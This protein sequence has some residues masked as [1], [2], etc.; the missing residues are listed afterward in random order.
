[1]EGTG[2]E[3][4]AFVLSSCCSGGRSRT[5]REQVAAEG[6]P[7]WSAW[8]LGSRGAVHAARE[9]WLPDAVDKGSGVPLEACEGV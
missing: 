3:G 6:R 4:G 1:M 9:A 7:G 8:C 2:A 5:S